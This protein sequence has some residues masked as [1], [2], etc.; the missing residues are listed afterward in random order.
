MGVRG[1]VSIKKIAIN[2]Y[3]MFFF[4]RM[5]TSGVSENAKSFHS[6]TELSIVLKSFLWK[7]RTQVM[8]FAIIWFSFKMCQQRNRLVYQLL[9]LFNKI[10]L[11]LPIPLVLFTRLCYFSPI[12]FKREIFN[13]LVEDVCVD[14]RK[15][16]SRSWSSFP[17]L[18]LRGYQRYTI[19]L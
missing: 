17:Y 12:Q 16:G 7:L 4:F 13:H 2:I 8:A 5:F 3:I 18:F 14:A 19:Q 1:S 15:R 6:A 9:V 11:P 10:C